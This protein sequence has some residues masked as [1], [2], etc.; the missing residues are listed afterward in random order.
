MTITGSTAASIQIIP[1][2][3]YSIGAAGTWGGGS[4]AIGWT[5]KAGN[6]VAFPDSPLSAD[7]GFVFSAPTG[8]LTLTPTSVT[9][10]TISLANCI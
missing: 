8:T 5:D 3:Y 9:S 7:G 10:I 1:G 6:T 4:L 2:Q